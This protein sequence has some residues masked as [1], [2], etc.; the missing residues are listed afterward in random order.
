MAGEGAPVLVHGRDVHGLAEPRFVRPAKRL[1]PR[2]VE[3][4][5]GVSV[6]RAPSGH[7]LVAGL[8]PASQVIGPGQLEGS[9][10]GLAPSRNQVDVGVVHRQ[11]RC[12]RRRVRLHR[13]RGELCAV[14]VRDRLRLLGHDTDDRSIAVADAHDQRASGRVQIALAVGVPDGRALRSNGNG[15]LAEEG[16]REDVAHVTR[17]Y[18][19]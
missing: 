10:D 4:T 12:E 5:A 3:R 8:V 14:D 16:S 15:Q 2:G 7:D 18:R 11:Q 19:V 6:V 9:L 13:L 17:D 1:P